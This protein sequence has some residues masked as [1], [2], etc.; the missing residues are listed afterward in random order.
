[1]NCM[2]VYNSGD[3]PFVD[4]TEEAY[5]LHLIVHVGQ[6][7]SN[8]I[9]LYVVAYYGSHNTCEIHQIKGSITV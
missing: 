3:F 4:Q 1:M 8:L 9:L 5:V 6:L 7:R 2:I